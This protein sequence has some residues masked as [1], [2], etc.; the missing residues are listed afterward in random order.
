MLIVFF[1]IVCTVIA[2]MT[3]W[4]VVSL[5]KQ[6]NDVADVAWG[7]GFIVVAITSSVMATELTLRALIVT[8]MVLIWGIRLALH[9]ASRHA[10]KPEDERYAAWRREWG[11]T[12]TIRSFLQVFMLQGILLTIISIPVVMINTAPSLPF[13]PL[14]IIGISVWLAGFTFEAVSDRQ[15]KQFVKNP[16]NRGKIMTGGLWRFSRHPNYFGEVTLWWGIYIVSLSVPGGWMSIIGPIMITFLILKVSGIP[17]LEKAFEA[18]P[19][20]QQYKRQ[21]SAFFPLP[22]KS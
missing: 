22:P 17:M 2:Y 9:I 13:T 6:R 4:F 5:L 1:I 18:N 15:L 14:D 19:D 20:F 3:V 21:T 8:T 12:V 11:S 16:T 7:P 10:G